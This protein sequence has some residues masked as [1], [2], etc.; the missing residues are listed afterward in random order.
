MQRALAQRARAAQPWAPTNLA[1]VVVAAVFAAFPSGLHGPGAAGDHVWV[2]ATAMRVGA[3]STGQALAQAV[4]E[5]EAGAPYVAGLLALRV[6]ALLER[7]VG[8]LEQRP[9][10]L[11]VDATG[12]D[13]PRGAGLALHLGA[14]L[15]L[16]SVGVTNRAL[17]A[18]CEA[19]GPRRGDAAPLLVGEE[20]VGACL[21][22]RV[23]SNPLLAHAAWRTSASTAASLVLALTDGGRRTP[24]PLRRAR[25]LARVARAAGEGRVGGAHG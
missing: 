9:D 6:G 2:A 7:A 1:E 18:H 22:V 17:V 21:R 15:D 11:L 8:A 5:G 4:V 24:E 20:V 3:A 12:R 23:G 14:I 19:P 25:T 16:P 13:H 10:A